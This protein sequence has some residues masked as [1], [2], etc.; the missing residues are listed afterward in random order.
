MLTLLKLQVHAGAD[1]QSVYATELKADVL[2]VG[3]D[4]DSLL[5]IEDLESGVSPCSLVVE[6]QGRAVL[7]VN[8]RALIQ[9]NGVP[10]TVQD[11][12]PGDVIAIGSA[13]LRVENPPPGFDF[14]IAVEQSRRTVT[15][16]EL[17]VSHKVVREGDFVTSIDQLGASQRTLSWLGITGALI[18]LLVLPWAVS[19]WLG[20]DSAPT[21]VSDALWSSGELHVSHQE[22]LGS[23]CQ[24]CHQR[25][26]ERVADSACVACHAQ[27]S[28]H[29]PSAVLAGESLSPQRC[30][31]CHLEHNEPSTLLE[32]GDHSCASCHF[33]AGL[34]ERHPQFEDYPVLGLPAV[35]FDHRA[36]A[37]KHYAATKKPFECRSCHEVDLAGRAM[38]TTGFDAMCIDCHGKSGSSRSEKVLHHGDQVATSDP[39]VFFTLP[40]IDLRNLQKREVEFPFWPDGARRSG[41]DGLTRLGITAMTWLLL[42]AETDTA[43]ALE[44]LRSARLKLSKLKKASEQDLADVVLLMASLRRLLGDLVA[45]PEATLEARLAPALGRSL[46]ATERAGLSGRLNPAIVKEAAGRWFADDLRS[47]GKA[48]EGYFGRSRQGSLPPMRA[49]L[50]GRS[51]VLVGSWA[52]RKYALRYQVSGH[53]D[54]FVT[55]W[56][57]LGEELLGDRDHGLSRWA[58]NRVLDDLLDRSAKAGRASGPGRCGK[59]HLAATAPKQ[60]VAA[61]W[62]IDWQATPGSASKFR[63][64]THVG[65][66]SDCR[67]CHYDAPN[68]V[69]YIDDFVA[70]DSHSTLPRSFA[71]MEKGLCVT[72]HAEK[73]VGGNTCI[74]C[75]NYHPEHVGGTAWVLT[76]PSSPAHQAATPELSSPKSK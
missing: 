46:S 61:A 68:S 56:A 21:V 13:Q 54:D 9:V 44:R 5:R 45:D 66:E 50:P 26:F 36:H 43:E 32:P 60:S 75:H 48:V 37:A 40:G 7:K 2:T 22:A 49:D 76:E 42:S 34:G 27:T 1:E 16:S 62:S 3:S 74:G 29:A 52:E 12:S 55:L 70:A 4:H 39:F 51:S 67:N 30:A 73:T 69:N 57:R 58:V 53:G 28:E 64:A 17:P 23:D 47:T 33:S 6:G 72:C 14:A 59:C 38:V 20:S 35:L 71:P 24:A 19:A 11:V 31:G 41:R 15:E 63:H 18:L 65:P 25:P 10:A 8:G